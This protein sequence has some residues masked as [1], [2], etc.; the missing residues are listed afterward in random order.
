VAASV[1]YLGYYLALS[2]WLTLRSAAS[3]APEPAA[4]RIQGRT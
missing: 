1:G 3:K 4:A 2:L